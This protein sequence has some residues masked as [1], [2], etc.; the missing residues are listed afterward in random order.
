MHVNTSNKAHAFL[1]RLRKKTSSRD[2]RR[3]LI[4]PSDLNSPDCLDFMGRYDAAVQAMLQEERRRL[5]NELVDLMRG[6]TVAESKP[7][8]ALPTHSIGIQTEPQDGLRLVSLVGDLGIAPVEPS[9]V[10]TSLT[11]VHRVGTM[12]IAPTE[13]PA[14]LKQPTLVPCVSRMEILPSTP[15]MDTAPPIQRAPKPLPP[16]SA[17]RDKEVEMMGKDLSNS[18]RP[19]VA[20]SYLSECQAPCQLSLTSH[21]QDGRSTREH[22]SSRRRDATAPTSSERMISLKK[23]T[24]I[25]WRGKNILVLLPD[26]SPSEYRALKP[27]LFSR[28]SGSD[29]LGQDVANPLNSPPEDSGTQDEARATPLQVERQLLF[30]RLQENPAHPFP[31]R[32]FSMRKDVVFRFG[33]EP[34]GGFQGLPDSDTPSALPQPTPD[35]EH[36]DAPSLKKRCPELEYRP[37]SQFYHG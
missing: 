29:S 28:P 9:I 14:G 15:A 10:A 24:K 22:T 18:P 30:P 6:T 5:K 11:L 1:E 13:P 21:Q 8:P 19:D 32:L 12:E 7:L 34:P 2:L 16:S 31:F 27:W 25:P 23:K 37:T 36:E 4:P 3:P 26:V 33:L 17:T 35:P 20:S